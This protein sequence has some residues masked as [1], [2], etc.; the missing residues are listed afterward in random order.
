[1]TSSGGHGGARAVPEE[2]GSESSESDGSAS[3]APEA[4]LPSPPAKDAGAPSSCAAPA[5]VSLGKSLSGT[6]CGGTVGLEN[7]SPCDS[8]GPAAFFYVDAP[9]GAVIQIEGTANF[10]VFGL[11][12]CGL[13]HWMNCGGTPYKPSLT[14]LRLFELEMYGSQYGEGT[15]GDFTITAVLASCT[16]NSEC[17][18]GTVCVMGTCRSC[19]TNAQCGPSGVCSGGSCTCTSDAQCD[20]GQQCVSG[21]CSGM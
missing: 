17:V 21:V 8:G 18:D 11:Q 16:A 20:T 3:E 1:M 2:A 4:G 5:H 12:D 19:A 9:A 10:A 14:S 6:T 15:C 7:G 13:N